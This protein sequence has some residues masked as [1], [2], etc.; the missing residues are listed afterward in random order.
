MRNISLFILAF[1]S[2]QVSAI[3]F[4]GE[5]NDKTQVIQN[6]FDSAMSG[7]KSQFIH[8]D[9]KWKLWT[10]MGEP[11]VFVQMKWKANTVGHEY[12][13]SL[14]VNEIKWEKLKLFN[15][16]LRLKGYNKKYSLRSGEGRFTIDTDPGVLFGSGANRW[17]YN[18]PGSPDWS[19]LLSNGD[20]KLS[21]TEAK[22]YFKDGLEITDVEIIH[23]DFSTNEFEQHLKEL[24]PIEEIQILKN[25]IREQISVIEETLGYPEDALRQKLSKIEKEYGASTSP[26]ERSSRSLLAE[27]KQIE[28]LFNKLIDLPDELTKHGVASAYEERS[29]EQLNQVEQAINEQDIPVDQAYITFEKNHRKEILERG[30]IKVKLGQA[31]SIAGVKM[32]PVPPGCILPRGQNFVNVACFKS[33]FLMGTYEITLGQWIKVMGEP[34]RHVI[35]GNNVAATISWIRKRCGL[36]C[37]VYNVNWKDTQEF[38][39]RLNKMNNT[40]FRLPTWSEW[41]YACRSGG[42]IEK[43]CG[44]DN[45]DELAWRDIPGDGVSGVHGVGLKKPNGLGIYDMAGNVSEWLEDTDIVGC[46]VH[47]ASWECLSDTQPTYDKRDDRSSGVGF[48]LVLDIE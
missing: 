13:R 23:A 28:Q 26:S 48:R 29:S 47:Q 46:S 37:P 17:S 34:G 42:K 22:Q 30:D 20:R 18:A 45:I 36:K 7:S 31:R 6:D 25:G 19:N 16:K 1:L 9:V 14:Y 11:V 43:F 33:G 40:A 2:F 41:L 21:K 3:S 35:A 12:S 38:I 27:K 32:S 10:L 5:F 44:G 8:Y 24:F 39:S 15:V 4:E